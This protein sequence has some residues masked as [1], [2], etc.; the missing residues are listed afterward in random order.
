M[1]CFGVEEGVRGEMASTTCMR[2]LIGMSVREVAMV[3]KR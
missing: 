2:E 3:T 1:A